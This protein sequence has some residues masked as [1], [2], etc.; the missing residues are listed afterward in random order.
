MLAYVRPLWRD[1][2]IERAAP[3][4]GFNVYV[5]APLYRHY[6]LRRA[7]LI[8]LVNAPEW[9]IEFKIG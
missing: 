7:A 6:N 5:D 2:V 9:K 1:A 4:W 3:G 8:P